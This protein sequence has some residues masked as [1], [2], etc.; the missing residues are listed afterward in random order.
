MTNNEALNILKNISLDYGD[1]SQEEIDQMDEALDLA[2][3]ALKRIDSLELA[4][5]QQREL[6]ERSRRD[7]DILWKELEESRAKEGKGALEIALESFGQL[8]SS[9]QEAIKGMSPE[10]I[11][12]LMEANDL[13]EDKEDFEDEEDRDTE[14]E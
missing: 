6:T 9:L 11:R 10:E 14:S 8:V 5:K 2:L 7:N 4:F 13:E 3:G 12:A 1:M